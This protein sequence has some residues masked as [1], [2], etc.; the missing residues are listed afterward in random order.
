MKRTLIATGL[1]LGSLAAF[2]QEPAKAPEAPK[3][4]EIAPAACEPKP[5]YPGV[6]KI[7]S[8]ADVDKLKVMVKKY[9]DCVKAYVTERNAAAKA[10][11]E[12]GNAAVREHN[13]VMKKFVDDQEAAKKAQEEKEKK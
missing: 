3:A 2:A 1:A 5:I 8:E 12:A 6:D 10:N 13:A 9:Q 4:S 11:T 7:K